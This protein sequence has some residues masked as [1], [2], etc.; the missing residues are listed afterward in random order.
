VHDDLVEVARIEPDPENPRQLRLTD[1]EYKHLS[2]PDW[3]NER[4]ESNQVDERMGL[5]L[6]LRDLADSM[7]STGVLQPIR[8]FRYGSGY[9]LA[10][11]ERRYWAAKLAG[12]KEIPARISDQRPSKV[13]TLQLVENL[14]R[15]DL[16]LAA[17]IRN[18]IAVLAEL[19]EDGEASAERFSTL[20]GMSQRQ[21]RRYLQVANGPHDVL[22][23]VV[24]TKV[25]G[26][27]AVAATVAGI[28]EDKLRGKI[29]HLLA[30]GRS[31][32]EAMNEIEREK[33]IVEKPTRGRPT[34]KVTLGTTK[35]GG[36]VRVLMERVLGK[37]AVPDVDWNDYR[38]VSK[39]W[40]QLLQ[41][42]ESTL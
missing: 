20:V 41:E 29:L 23:A 21:A 30:L 37:E 6:R 12:L 31:L 40:Q 7:Q 11:G 5:L 26:D 22:A 2:D 39:A 24:E 13:R 1:E 19:A 42:L 28:E 36:L 15:E 14:H 18:V 32:K 35:N 16:D 17:R 3:I 27:L 25:I 9:R 10:F 4:R 33:E 8:V 38:A 34:T